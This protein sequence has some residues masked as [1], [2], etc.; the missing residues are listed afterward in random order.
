MLVD[1]V[2]E[3]LLD[4]DIPSDLSGFGVRE[5]DIPAMAA[6]AM[7]SGNILSNPRQTGQKD[8]EALYR[9]LL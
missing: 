6:D 8:I 5:E 2:R 1:E 7:K 9:S 3:L 4:L